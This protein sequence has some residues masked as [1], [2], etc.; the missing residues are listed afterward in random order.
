[1]VKFVHKKHMHK[2]KGGVSFVVYYSVTDII[3]G[4][5]LIFLVYFFAFNYI[6]DN[7]YGQSN[8]QD[9]IFYINTMTR[10]YHKK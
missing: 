8:A 3:L 4:F 10:V 7:L 1:M 5:L 6:K 9:G 2:A